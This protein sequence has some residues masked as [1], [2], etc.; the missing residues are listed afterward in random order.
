MHIADVVTV[1][2]VVVFLP[3]HASNREG[4]NS[5]KLFYL[6]VLPNRHECYSLKCVTR[7]CKEVVS[8]ARC[9]SIRM[10]RQSWPS[11][12]DYREYTVRGPVG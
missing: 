8:P 4:S 2:V 3:V 7:H 5:T 1:A 6:S 11:Q 12:V 9:L 10:K